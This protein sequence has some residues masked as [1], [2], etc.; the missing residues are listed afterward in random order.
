M[1]QER[2]KAVKIIMQR[3]QVNNCPVSAVKTT[4]YRDVISGKKV[5]VNE[6]QNHGDL[7]VHS[8]SVRIS[9]FDEQ[10]KLVG[11]IKDYKY[12][13]VFAAPGAEFGAQ[14]IIACPNES[15][16][17]FAISV[18]HVE[19]EEDYF[20]DESTRKLQSRTEEPH[21]EVE[22]A[23]EFDDTITENFSK[24]DVSEIVTEKSAIDTDT[25]RGGMQNAGEVPQTEATA[26]P[27]AEPAET[28]AKTSETT[29]KTT[30]TD[31]ESTQLPGNEQSGNAGK[32]EK[33]PVPG[34][35]RL[36]IALLIIGILGAAAYVA[37]DKYNKYTDYNRGAAYMANGSYEYAINVYTRL[38]DYEDAPTLLIEAKKAYANSLLNAGEFEAAI[39]EYGKLAGQEEKIAECYNAWVLQLCEEK[40]EQEALELLQNANV[41]FDVEIVKRVKYEIGVSLYEGKAYKDAVTYL[42]EAE[43]Y[44]DSKNLINDSYYQLGLESLN[45]GAYDQSLEAF[46]KV[47]DYKDSKEQITRVNY[48]RGKDFMGSGAYE[49]AIQCF[50]QIT[51]YEDCAEL[52]KQCYYKQACD[53]LTKTDYEKAMEYFKMVED[54]EDSTDKY[55]E[56]LYAYLIEAM[57]TEVTK[58]TMDLLNELP[59]N[60]ED[61]AAIIK[62]LKKYVDHVGEYKWTTSNDK[63]INAQGGF[64]DPVIVKL[65]YSDG[66]VNFTVD[67]HPV[68]LKLFAYK[69]DTTS[70]TYT[71]LNTTTITRTF[72]GKIHTY[73]KV[74]E[75]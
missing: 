38:G 32:K 8:I 23:P 2:F 34:V 74:V 13:D 71:M 11:T 19:L 6:F 68:D 65:S 43:G 72:N 59:K 7:V 1:D 5:F 9:C 62:T 67:D 42:T 55:N 75:E 70:D 24:P 39:N 37:L 25:F 48:L 29:A 28:T 36:L 18:T 52:I 49:D 21:V 61:S 31:S 4:I 14:K 53:Y 41:E 47:R 33:K 12:N 45:N 60:Y 66:T 73:K 20:W 64:E 69:S 51:D 27:M 46:E 57:K 26:E 58:E 54:Y 30:Q 44:E 50:E 3:A 40:K 35:V 63:E 15:I 10:V 56:A 17:S 16:N 22:M